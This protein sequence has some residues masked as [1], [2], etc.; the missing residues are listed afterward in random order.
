M[1]N[2]KMSNT[3]IFKNVGSRESTEWPRRHMKRE[4]SPPAKKLK[5]ESSVP[6]HKDAPVHEI[7]GGSSV[8]QYLNKHLTQHLLEGLKK[9]SKEKPEDPLASLGQFL[10]QRSDELKKAENE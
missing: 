3:Y 2:A 9:V 1:H 4:E 6:K 7:V 5:T 10:I 8:R